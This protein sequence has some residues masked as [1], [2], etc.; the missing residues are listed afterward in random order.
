MLKRLSRKNLQKREKKMSKTETPFGGSLSWADS[1]TPEKL[2]GISDLYSW[3]ANYEGFTPFKKFLDLIGHSE[4]NYGA[5]LANW[6]KPAD[7]L[8]YME[9]GFLAKALDNY[10][11]FPQDSAD[12]ISKLL[13]IEGRFG[14]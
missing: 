11:D 5:N 9:L 7:S 14:L 2:A 13:E 10:S 12:Y 4:E 3:S 1:N 6:E 8:G